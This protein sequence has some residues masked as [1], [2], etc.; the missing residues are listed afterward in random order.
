VLTI[1]S[2]ALGVDHLLAAG[3]P[4]ERL[5]DVL[6]QGVDPAGEFAA[7]ILGN[8]ETMDTEKARGDVVAAG[9]GVKATMSLRFRPWCWNAPT[10]RRYRQAIEAATGLKT[11]A[12]TDDERLLRPW[13]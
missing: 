2:A 4:Q 10:C 5:Q 11:W 6:V 12:L 9:L 8:R 1:S 3:V 7:A 13:R